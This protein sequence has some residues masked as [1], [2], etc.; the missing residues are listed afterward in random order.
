MESHF[1]PLGTGPRGQELRVCVSRLHKFG[2][3]AFLLA[4]FARARHK[5]LCADLGTGCGIIPMVL[6]KKYDP[7]KIYAVELQPEAAALCRETVAASGAEETVLPLEADLRE[8]GPLIP[9]CSLDL[10][11][12]NPP[13]QDPGTGLLSE[14]PGRRQ[15]RHELTCTLDD[16]C[17]AAARMLRF[18]G[19]LC[20]CQRPERLADVICTLRAHRLEPKRMRLAAKDAGSLPWL[21]L[22]EAKYGSKPFLQ[23]EPPLFSMNP[24]GSF[25]DEMLNIYGNIP[26]VHNAERKEAE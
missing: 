19:R 21:V 26:T 18:G 24:D 9:A 13:F 17:R 12:C 23:V 5:D 1:E 15:A 11:T 8:L 20:L 4:D 3:D 25:T 2:T 22:I 10:I 14:I 6:Y 7:K 16:L